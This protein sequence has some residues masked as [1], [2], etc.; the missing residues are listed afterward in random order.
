MRNETK[1]YNTV[2]IAPKSQKQSCSKR[3]KKIDIPSI[4]R[5]NIKSSKI[6]V[7]DYK[8]IK[9][10]EYR[11]NNKKMDNSDKLATLDTQYE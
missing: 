9:V 8:Q 10:R 7:V 6:A 11:M 3:G 1:Q 2:W 5:R 4:Q